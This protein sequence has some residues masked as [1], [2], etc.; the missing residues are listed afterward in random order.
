MQLIFC[1]ALVLIT[2]KT[3]TTVTTTRAWSNH[4]V[5]GRTT[6]TTN[7]KLPPHFVSSCKIVSPP[8]VTSL[9]FSTDPDGAPT[10]TAKIP[11]TVANEGD[12]DEINAN[13]AESY[14]LEWDKEHVMRML[15]QQN[16]YD[17]TENNLN[18]FDDSGKGALFNGRIFAMSEC[19][20]RRPFLLRG[21]F[22][23]DKLI[24][25]RSGDRCDS[26]KEEDYDDG[27]FF[28]GDGYWP[29][30]EDV[31][32]ISSDEE[33]EARVITHVTGDLKSFD[34]TCGP[35]SHKEGNDWLSKNPTTTSKRQE[36]KRQQ[37]HR[38]N[39]ENNS[40]IINRRRET[41]VVNDVDRYYPPLADWIHSTF[42]FLPHWRMD[43]GQISLAEEGG[44]IGP[45]VDNY[46]VFLIQMSGRRVWQVGK[47]EIGAK[48]E[49]ERT[50][51]GLDVRILGDWQSGGVVGR[52]VDGDGIGDGEGSDLEM[53]DWIVNPGDLL[54]LPPRVAHC[55]TAVTDGSMT[56][57]VGCR[58]PSA[59]DLVSKLAE[60]LS[61]SLDDYAVRRYTDEDLLSEMEYIDSPG[62]LTEKA[63]DQAKQ[64]VLDSL[65][66][67]LNDEEIWDEFFGRY[68]TEQKRVRNNYPIQLEDWAEEENESMDGN[69]EEVDVWGNAKR[70]VKSVLN[71]E[72]VFYHAEGIAYAYSSFASTKEIEVT[73]HRL[74]ANGEMWESRS[75]PDS[76]ESK[77]GQIYA[78]IANNR[79]IDRNLIES[80]LSCNPNEE[81][82]CL[83]ELNFLEKLVSI[84]VLY[85]SD[86]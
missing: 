64:L 58:A 31:V 66:T 83:E 3:L 72:G 54:Y 62:E 85:G 42:S 78:T 45:H 18:D 53:E 60:K 12:K 80:A 47:R 75:E 61:T 10:T 7:T 22:D 25:E 27:Q 63:K 2:V 57:S 48:E 74:F 14:V 46:D 29:S 15:S 44:G 19:W 59:S 77:M 70:A 35:L 11:R 82:L 69:E 68:A 84:G 40:A 36:P 1:L 43:D 39:D 76:N 16:E 4:I 86:E 34:L 5:V 81:N 30:W 65:S 20:G 23:P 8:S 33:A 28:Q 51:D 41:L 56:L 13:A 67:M 24:S 17:E 52:F 50:L 71:G 55:G 32:D 73:L 21:A 26:F 49:M 37:R 38:N 9:K 79:R 6:E